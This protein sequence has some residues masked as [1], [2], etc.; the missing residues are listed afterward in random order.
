MISCD[1][2]SE[3]FRKIPKNENLDEDEDEYYDSDEDED[4]YYDSDNKEYENLLDYSL[5]ANYDGQGSCKEMIFKFETEDISHFDVDF[6]TINE[7]FGPWAKA[8]NWKLTQDD[9]I[10]T[11]KRK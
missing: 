11:I 4:E 3:P 8:V 5:L 7:N 2:V 6:K 10:I 9:C 1:T